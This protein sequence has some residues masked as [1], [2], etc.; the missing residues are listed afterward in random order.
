MFQIVSVV[1]LVYRIGWIVTAVCAFIAMHIIAW[2]MRR[3]HIGDSS[4]IPAQ[5]KHRLLIVVEI[6][7]IVFSVA[8][9]TIWPFIA[10]A[11]VKW[12]IIARSL[13]KH[14]YL[15]MIDIGPA[16]RRSKRRR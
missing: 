10:V 13:K 4:S 3:Q 1:W 9:A 12:R 7:A 16:K 6:M 11:I 2:R 15:N 14:N 5:V 8:I